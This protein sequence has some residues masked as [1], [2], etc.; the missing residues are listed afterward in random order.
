LTGVARDWSYLPEEYHFAGLEILLQTVVFAGF[1]KTI[2]A[3]SMVHDVGV[4]PAVLKQLKNDQET[5]AQRNE[6][7][8]NL[9][10]IIYRSQYGKLRFEMR[11]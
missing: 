9:L 1:Q 2:N 10:K 8:E 11:N 6:K 5:S 4:S 3:L 7:G